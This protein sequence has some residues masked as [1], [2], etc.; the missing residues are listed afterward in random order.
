[1]PGC[2]LTLIGSTANSYRFSTPE[3]LIG[4]GV[5]A[6]MDP[7]PPEISLLDVPAQF[8]SVSRK[9]ARLKQEGGSFRLEGLGK[10]GTFVNGELMTGPRTLKS[11]DRVRLGPEGPE[12]DF[13]LTV[14]A[15]HAAA[16]VD[17]VL[18][19]GCHQVLPRA[20]VA[21]HVC[22]ARKTAP[23]RAKEAAF[24][25]MESMVQGELHKRFLALYLMTFLLIGGLGTA[26]WWFWPAPAPPPEPV[27]ISKYEPRFD[28]DALARAVYR[29]SFMDKA[30]NVAGGGT[31][32][33][34]TPRVLATNCHITR[35]MHELDAADWKLECADG[36]GRVLQGATYFHKLEDDERWPAQEPSYDVGL[37]FLNA[38]VLDASITLARDNRAPAF[39]R[40]MPVWVFGFPGVMGYEKLNATL[41]TGIVSI[42]DANEPGVFWHTAMSGPG[43]SGSPVI[44]AEG[45]VVGVLAGGRE[46]ETVRA[47]PGNEGTELATTSIPSGHSYA[48]KVEV[49]REL[50]QKFGVAIGD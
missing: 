8:G 13:T 19:N 14:E 23:Q 7:K 16:N 6:V 46:Y 15:E 21:R 24:Y 4:R 5:D 25:A 26:V 28:D 30:G 39:Q 11:G 31:A 48:I 10:H 27:P 41:T 36:S 45:K 38:D 47:V 17:Q 49:L 37:V 43:N 32:F 33:A 35:A 20:E 22:P 2:R 12:F 40:K 18:C 29:V 50:L 3:V 9:H 44:N 1:M 42:A 34:V